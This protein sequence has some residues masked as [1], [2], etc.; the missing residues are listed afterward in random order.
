MATY[1]ELDEWFHKLTRANPKIAEL[2]E[3]SDF[4]KLVHGHKRRSTQVPPEVNEAME[5]LE[6]ALLMRFAA[7]TTPPGFK[8]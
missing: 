6:R 1:K 3:A 2:N 7:A 4:D 5:A 8:C